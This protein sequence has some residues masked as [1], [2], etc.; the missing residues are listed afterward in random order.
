MSVCDYISLYYFYL[1]K[2]K[3]E[4]K[5]LLDGSPQKLVVI[6]TNI[7]GTESDH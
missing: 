1:H 5:Y 7:V 4:I 6:I 3:P 2:I